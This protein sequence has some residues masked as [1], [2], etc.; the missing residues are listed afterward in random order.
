MEIE[1]EYANFMNHQGKHVQT[2]EEFEHR[3]SNFKKTDDKLKSFNDGHH[4]S[5]VRHNFMS[6]LDPEE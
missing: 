1:F 4:K 6:D 5:M 3:K 2:R